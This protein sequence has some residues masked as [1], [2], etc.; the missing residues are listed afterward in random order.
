[1]ERGVSP[2]RL[3]YFPTVGFVEARVRGM[4]KLEGEE[5]GVCVYVKMGRTTLWI[6]DWNRG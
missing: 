5:E 4:T 1:M 6:V 2:N 3:L